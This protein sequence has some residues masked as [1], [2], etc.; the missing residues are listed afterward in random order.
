MSSVQD[1]PEADA[2]LCI[3]ACPEQALR[4]APLRG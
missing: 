3:A 4:L 2:K 1:T